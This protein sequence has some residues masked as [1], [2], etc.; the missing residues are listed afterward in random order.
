MSSN[1]LSIEELQ[2]ALAARDAALASR[3]AE[4]ASLHAEGRAL[5]QTYQAVLDNFSV[6]KKLTDTLQHTPKPKS[7]LEKP[8]AY[9]GKDKTGYSTFVSQCK[10]YIYG[11]PTLF[12]TDQEKIAFMISLLRNSAYK[13]F[14]PYIE[15]ADEKRPHFLK[16]FTAFLEQ[17]QLYLGDPDREH[18]ITNKLRALTQTGS[19]AAYASTF[20]QLSAFLAWNDPALQA[21]YYTGLKPDVRNMLSL[22]DDPTLVADLSA[23]AIKADNRLHQSRQEAKATTKPHSQHSQQRG[24]SA[25]PPTRVTTNVTT[26]GPTPMDNNLCLYCGEGGHQQF[27]KLERPLPSCTHEDITHAHGITRS[28]PSPVYITLASTLDTQPFD[29]LVLPLDFCL[30]PPV[31]GSALIDSGATSLFIDDSFVSRHGLVR[32][33]HSTPIPLFVIDGRPIASGH[34]T[35][36][37]RL[38]ITLGGHSQVIQADVTQLGTYPLVLGTPWLRLFN[39]SINWADNTLTFSCSQC[40]LGHPTSVDVGLQGLPLVHSAPDLALDVALASSDAFDQILVDEPSLGLINRDPAHSYLFSTSE[41][42]SPSV[43]PVGPPDSAEYLDD[44]RSA[45]PSEYHHLLQAFSKAQ[46]DTLP[47]HRPFDLAIEIEDGKQPPFGPLYPLSEKELQA[48]STWIDENLSKGFIRPSTSPAGAPILFVRKKDGSLRLCVDYRGLN[49]VTLKNRYPLPLIPEALDRLC[50]AKIFTKLDLRSGYN[51]VR[52]KGGDEWKTA[53]RTRYGHFECLVMP[54]GLTNAPAAFQHLMNSIFRDFLDVTVLVYLDDIL[55]FSDSPSDHVVHV[56]EVLHRLI[57]NQL[58]CNPKKCEFHQTSTEYLGFIISPDGVSMSP[59]KVD[60]ITS[61][62]T[63]TT[64]KELQQFLGFANF[65]RRFIQGY[66]RIISPLTRLLKKGAVFDFDSLALAA[67]NRLKSLFA[68]DIILRHYDPSLPCVIESDASDYAIS[69][70]LSQSVDSQLRPVAFFSRKMTPAEQNYEIHD[71]ELL[72]IFTDHNALQYFQTTKVLTRR[73]ARWSETVN[74]LN[75]IIKYRPGAQNN[76]A[77]ALSRRPD[78][79]AGGKACEQPGVV[80]LCPSSISAT[81]SPSSEIADLIKSRLL[82]DPAS[83]RVI[84]DLNRDASLH[85]DFALQD[86]FLL[87]RHKIYV[88]DFEPLKVKLLHQVHDSPPSG[89]FGQAKSF[90]LLDRNFVWPGMH[91]F[92][93]DYVRSCDSCQRNKPSHHRKH[94]P[95]HSLPVPTKPWSSLSMDHIVDL[96]PSS[97]FDSV[98]VVVDRLTKEAHFIPARKSDTSKTLASQFKTHIFQ[99]H[100]LPGDI[101]SDRGTTFTSS[102]WTEFLKMLDIRPNLSTAFHPESDGQTERTNQILKHYLRHFCDYHQD[103]WHDLLPLAEFSYNNS[104]HS[105]IGMTPF[106]ASRGYHPRLEVTLQETPVPDVRQHLAGLRNAQQ[107]AQDQIRRSQES[108]ARY[109]NL[110]RAPTPPLVLGQQVMLNRR[111]IRT[112]RRSSKLDSNKLG[113][114]AIKR[115]INPVAYE[116]DLPLTMRIHPVFHVSLLEPYRPNTLP[117]PFVVERIL[118]SRVRHGLLQ[119]FIDWT[120]YGPQDREWVDASNF[121]DDDALVLDF[122]RSKPRKP[123]ADRI[124][125]LAELDA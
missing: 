78:F 41:E 114:F 110:R 60:S 23:K 37:V 86:G 51:L 73:Q 90:E 101:V 43:F 11:N 89:H 44:L 122:H 116:L 99:L 82:H 97:G 105:S 100:G 20:F 56:Q 84:N 93:N 64:L 21:Q 25:S 67:F 54:F 6:V 125:H 53:F 42:A 62:P 16:D 102:W 112:T 69:A 109:A 80:I 30:E 5:Q 121:D 14:E 68:S 88:P 77:D 12:T 35:H 2:A 95:L 115:I 85:P 38:M 118:D 120:G 34:V 36:F 124:Q 83:L 26:Q 45:L 55:I 106:F 48:L 58:Y 63:P 70:I 71:K 50:S 1:P 17:A 31:S 24:N 123:G 9:D 76:K 7:P 59:S 94:G 8:P 57:D 65:Y 107:L 32:R 39:P 28:P 98:L 74:H 18:T 113:P 4:I 10:F 72:A 103:D 52:I 33:P 61:W 29:H 27:E 119:Y 92:V 47:P 15:L 22:Q 3:E 79:A 49:A 87:Q 19:A 75:Y 96:P 104:F 91:A 66:S 40:T 46:A 13:V 111:N 81:F 117:S 108:H